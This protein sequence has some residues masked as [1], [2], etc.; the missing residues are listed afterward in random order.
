M[1]VARDVAG[2][3][4]EE[5]KAQVGQYNPSLASSGGQ[6]EEDQVY[7]LPSLKVYPEWHDIKPEIV[8]DREVKG[9]SGARWDIWR[10]YVQGKVVGLTWGEFRTEVQD[11]NPQLAG[12]GAKFAAGKSYLLPRNAGEDDYTRVVYTDSRGGYRFSELSPGR[13]ALEVRADGYHLLQQD[14]ELSA[15]TMLDLALS[16]AIPTAT[17]RAAGGFVEA[18]DR[19]FVVQGQPFRPFIG[20]NLRALAHYGKGKFEFAGQRDQL[21]HARDMGVRVVRF[22]LANKYE[23]KEEV[24]ARFAAMLDL[25][26]NEF[27]EMYVIPAFTDLYIDSELYPRGDDNYYQ[28]FTHPADPSIRWTILKREW[29]VDGYKEHYL[30]LVKYI[31]GDDRFRNEP[32]IFAWE[33][34][35]ELKVDNGQGIFVKFNHAVADAIRNLDGNHMITTGMMSTHHAG[36]GKEQCRKLYGYKNLDFITCHIYDANYI[37]NDAP[38]SKVVTKPF[39]VEEAGFGAGHGEDRAERVKRD[40]DAM[41]APDCGAAG[42]MQWG[43]MAGGDNRD[44]DD[45]RGMDWI[46]HSDWNSLFEAY[47]QRAL[48]FRPE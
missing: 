37:D 14:I 2:I 35:N 4:W 11:Q 44:G 9:I 15:D 19:R 20:I 38:V 47:R 45:D 32:R 39:I 41:F 28:T 33:I 40:M 27:K 25:M 29:F 7:T 10:K 5:F 30:P 43:F 18:L 12:N 1:F 26:S 16:E 24:R 42:Y 34:G 13:Y 17:A 8:W 22:F 23:S 21:K 31:V 6:F 48:H 3:T 46:F 36:L